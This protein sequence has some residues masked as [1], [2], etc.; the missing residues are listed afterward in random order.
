[1]AKRSPRV[2]GHMQDTGQS[3]QWV[4]RVPLVNQTLVATAANSDKKLVGQ[5]EY[6][7]VRVGG[8]GRKGMW[9]G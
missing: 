1:M 7:R 9:V 8:M 2:E 3:H 5:N 4:S 6:T